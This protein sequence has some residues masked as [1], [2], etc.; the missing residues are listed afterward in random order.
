MV[1]REE[2]G[3]RVEVSPD[4]PQIMAAT[5]TNSIDVEEASRCAD[6]AASMTCEVDEAAEAERRSN[7][8]ACEVK[9]KEFLLENSVLSVNLPTRFP[10]QLQ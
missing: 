5:E 3:S 6:E 1:S 9:P 4:S 10:Q 8:A 2:R 7:V